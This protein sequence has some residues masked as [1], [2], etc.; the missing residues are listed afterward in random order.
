[1]FSAIIC[2][3]CFS[4]G[5]LFTTRAGQFNLYLADLHIALF[6]PPILVSLEIFFVLYSYGWPAIQRNIVEMTGIDIYYSAFYVLIVLVVATLVCGLVCQ[7]LSY[8]FILP[9]IFPLR[10]SMAGVCL[11][12]IPIIVFLLVCLVKIN[13][14]EG[15]TVTTKLRIVT[16]SNIE[17]CKCHR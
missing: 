10:A 3:V 2:F 11:T 1:M 12:L 16:Q 6:C 8:L 7:V 4:V 13:N 5:L 15:K 14:T 17:E 9:R